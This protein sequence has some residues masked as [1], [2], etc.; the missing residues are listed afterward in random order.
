MPDA[1]LLPDLP[2]FAEAIGASNLPRPPEVGAT[3]GKTAWADI[4]I[5]AGEPPK[6]PK[7]AVVQ[8]HVRQFQYQPGDV[9]LVRDE[10]IHRWR[11]V[12]VTSGTRGGTVRLDGHGKKTVY[13]P[14]TA[15]KPVKSRKGG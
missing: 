1:K 12:L 13:I 2:R 14:Y 5:T 6:A 11:G 3:T 10:G 9:V 7:D 15:M 8:E 4:P